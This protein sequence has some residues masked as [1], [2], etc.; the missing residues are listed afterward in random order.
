MSV[1]LQRSFLFKNIFKFLIIYL[2]AVF[3]LLLI[4]FSIIKITLI[5]YVWLF[6]I[7]FLVYFSITF[8]ILKIKSQNYSRLILKDLPF[9]LNNLA[10]DLDRNMSLK[11]ALENKV[12]NSI[13]GEKIKKALSLV[14][15]G[16]SLENSLYIVSKNSYDLN[17]TFNQLI[18]IL[19]VG[20]KNKAT[21]LRLLAESITEEQNYLIKKYATKL[22]L[23]TLIFVIVSAVVPAMFLMFLLVASN[24]LEITFSSLTVIIVS[25]VLFPLIDMFL[26]LIMK[27]NNP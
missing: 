8:F 21:N 7:F 24:F 12:D 9:F 15:K 14:K 3:I 27:S 6:V 22:N 25:V 26:L 4:D 23:I 2:I 16:H 1:Y 18:D 17:R 20:N 5:Y 13:I 19:R 11:I 10:N